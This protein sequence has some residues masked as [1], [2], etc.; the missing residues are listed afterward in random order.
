MVTNKKTEA[1]VQV[2]SKT[3]KSAKKVK[4][5]KMPPKEK[6]K[7]GR[8]PWIPEYEKIEQ[9]SLQGLTD[10]AIA[11]LCKISQAE[12]CKK[13]TQLPQLKEAL[14]YGKARGEAMVSGKLFT[15]AMGGDREMIKM[16]LGRKCGWSET[17]IIDTPHKPLENMTLEELRELA[18]G[19][20]D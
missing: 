13:K 14:D 6:K 20:K 1:A 4:S 16:Y 12:F 10:K 7:V 8:K 3:T 18:S 2:R 11:D 17:T 9:W 5:P 19:K 15:M